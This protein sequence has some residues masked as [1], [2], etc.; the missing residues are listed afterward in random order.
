MEPIKDSLGRVVCM[1]CHQKGTC[2]IKYRQMMISMKIPIGETLVVH[3]QDT[4]T[5]I[6]RHPEHGFVISD[7]RVNANS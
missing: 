7:T 6:T 3:R 1:A 2:Q 5:H 4:V